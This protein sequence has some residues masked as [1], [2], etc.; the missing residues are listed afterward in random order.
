ML[1]DTIFFRACL[2]WAHIVAEMTVLFLCISACFRLP[3][4]PSSFS[5]PGHNF[6]MHWKIFKL[7]TM[8]VHH[9]VIRRCVAFNIK[10]PYFKGQ[11]HTWQKVDKHVVT[12]IICKWTGSTFCS[13]VSSYSFIS[14]VQILLSKYGMHLFVMQVECTVS[15]SIV[16]MTKVWIYP[17]CCPTQTQT[18]L[19]SLVLKK[20]TQKSLLIT[21]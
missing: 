6:C 12:S 5:C 13:Q 18:P 11:G 16:C 21:K 19:I 3:A 20:G 2:R 17:Q 14:T 7:L 1:T 8:N 4:R 15:C 9:Y 10:S